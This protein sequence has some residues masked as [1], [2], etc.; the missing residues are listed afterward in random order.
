MQ[1]N[2]MVTRE[3]PC[4][5]VV[6]AILKAQFGNWERFVSGENFHDKS[7]QTPNNEKNKIKSRLE[8]IEALFSPQKC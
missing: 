3:Q 8:I 4:A 1:N 7:Y 5:F 2:Q 6:F